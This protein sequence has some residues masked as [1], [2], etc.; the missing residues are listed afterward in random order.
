MG[1]AGRPQPDGGRAARDHR[2]PRDGRGE[3]RR[4]GLVP[5]VRARPVRRAAAAVRG[6][7]NPDDRRA[8]DRVPRRAIEVQWEIAADGPAE[9]RRAVRSLIEQGVHWI[10]VMLTGGLYSAHKTVEDAQLTDDELEAVLDIASKRSVPVAAHCGSARVAERFARGG[11][12]GGARLR[13]G[14]KGGRGDGHGRHLA[15]ADHRGHPRRGD[16]AADGWPDHARLRAPAPPPP[17]AGDA[18]LRRGGRAGGDWSGPEPDRPAAAR[19]AASCCSG[20]G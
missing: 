14:R 13:T 4:S 10:K 20:P 16:D 6:R 18:G 15:G 1:G 8:R 5:R 2:R 3:P 17:R 12:V 9:M 11:P 7:G 19:R